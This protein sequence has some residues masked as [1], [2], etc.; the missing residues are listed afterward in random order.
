M[1]RRA[2]RLYSIGSHRI[3]ES[4]MTDATEHVRRKD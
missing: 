4:G 3:T 1:D 2:G